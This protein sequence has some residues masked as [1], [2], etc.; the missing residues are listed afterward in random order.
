VY[1]YFGVKVKYY[2]VAEATKP[3]PLNSFRAASKLAPLR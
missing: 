1:K 3:E 2:T